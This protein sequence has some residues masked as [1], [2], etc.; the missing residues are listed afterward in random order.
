[1]FAF[2][3]Y[4]PTRL[5]ELLTLISR[6]SK[7][8]RPFTPHP[9]HSHVV[10]CGHFDFAAVQEFLREFF[11]LDHGLSAMRTQ[12][13]LLGWDEPNEL[14]KTLLDDPRY[15]KRVQYVK[16][17]ATRFK[18]LEKVL[19]SKADACFVLND[20]ISLHDPSHGKQTSLLANI[21]L[22]SLNIK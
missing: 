5:S 1:M 22:I 16:G 4:I 17:S 12:V 15:H 11:C 20:K 7:Y 18:D 14:L 3:M 8:T 9:G 21:I 13:V 6:K 10:V 19:A 2:T